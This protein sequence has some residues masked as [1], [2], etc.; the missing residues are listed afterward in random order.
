MI[1]W[2]GPG[3]RSKLPVRHPLTENNQPYRDP[4]T[5]AKHLVRNC[6]ETARVETV[7]VLVETA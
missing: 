6:V 4:T 2:L 3:A 1:E 7:Q 5:A